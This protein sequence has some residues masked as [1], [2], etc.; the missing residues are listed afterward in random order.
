[1]VKLYY[2][3]GICSIEGH[4]SVRG[5]EINFNGTIDSLAKSHL[6][7]MLKKAEAI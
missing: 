6:R 1:M 3:N 7:K 4:D 5:V 2:G